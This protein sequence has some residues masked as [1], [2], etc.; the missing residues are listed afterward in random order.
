MDEEKTSNFEEE[1]EKKK[2]SYFITIRDLGKEFAA[3]SLWINHLYFKDFIIYL[4][5]GGVNDPFQ[6]I[7][8]LLFGTKKPKEILKMFEQ[9]SGVCGHS[10]SVGEIAFKCKTCQTDPTC[11]ICAK[12]FQNGDHEGHE[13]AMQRN[14]SGICDWFV[15]YFDFLVETQVHGQ[16]KDFVKIIQVQILIH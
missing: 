4:F 5:T 10:W 3:E 16:K 9:N 1:L 6:W 8:T 7:P 2:L 11:A 14:S 15:F 12:C 13:Y